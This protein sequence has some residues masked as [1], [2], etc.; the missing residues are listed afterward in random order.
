MEGGIMSEKTNINRRKFLKKSG[1]IGLAVS[2]IHLISNST[3][4]KAK[5]AMASK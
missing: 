3:K 5:K 1:K 2:L 4:A